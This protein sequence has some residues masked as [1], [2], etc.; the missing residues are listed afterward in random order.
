MRRA[1]VDFRIV[2][3]LSAVLGGCV[4]GTAPRQGAPPSVQRAAA[5][6]AAASASTQLQALDQLSRGL[7]L[8]FSEPG[9]RWALGRSLRAQG[10]THELKVELST[11]LRSPAS[12]GVVGAAAA[13]LDI[14]RDA[15]LS[16]LDVLPSM[17][18]YMP[19]SSHRQAWA[20]EAVLV[21]A[22]LRSAD[23]LSAFDD[24]GRKVALSTQGP[25]STPTFVIVPAEANFRS[26]AATSAKLASGRVIPPYVSTLSSTVCD[27]ATLLYVCAPANSGGSTTIPAT[28]PSGVYMTFSGLYDTGEP[29]Y[30]GDPEIEVH[31]MGPQPTDAAGVSRAVACSGEHQGGY[32]NFNQNGSTWSGGVMVMTEA[33]MTQNRYTLGNADS[34]AAKVLV[35]EDDDGSCVIRDDP[36]R[37]LND[38][39]WVATSFGGGVALVSQCMGPACGITS[40]IV[41]L[42]GVF[43]T[44]NS[45]FQ[46]N[47]DYLGVAVTRAV[48]PQY[49]NPAASHTLIRNGV[50]VNGGVKLVYHKYGTAN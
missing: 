4:D 46:T 9:H 24:Q 49:T 33:V 10:I 3:A 29:W 48:A 42:L 32:Y 47:D 25:P 31:V 2:V 43:H 23:A 17:E 8:A 18:F 6:N 45:L 21:A 26:V 28:A 37:L 11:F 7:A 19:S 39:L 20:G 30:R 36:G 40:L 34:R 15:F 12:S 35:Y 14:S 13:R 27:P 38:V 1:V 5:G 22:Q 41:T 44:T 16:L 50:Q